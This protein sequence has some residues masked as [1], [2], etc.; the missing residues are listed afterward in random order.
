MTRTICGGPPEST[1]SP[2]GFRSNRLRDAD[3][4]L[5][6]RALPWLDRRILGAG[7]GRYNSRLA[8]AAKRAGLRSSLA[9][10]PRRLPAIAETLVAVKD[11]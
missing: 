11:F 6:E 5:A 10:V 3:A 9:S 8:I 1:L 7:F 2:S 4:R